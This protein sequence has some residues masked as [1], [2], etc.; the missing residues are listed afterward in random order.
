MT[1]IEHPETFHGLPVF[2]LPPPGEEGSTPASLPESGSVAWRLDCA[3]EGPAFP[4]IWQRFLD[5]VDPAAVRALLIGPWWPDGYTSFAPV[6]ELIVSDAARFPALRALFLADVVGEECEVS[7]L[8]MSDITSLVEAYPR[9]EELVVRG[10]G[11]AVPEEEKLQLRP[12]RHLALKS[13]R[14]ES[15]GLPG[16]VVRAVG[17]SELPALERLE[18]WFGASWYGGDATV[19]DMRPVLSGSGLPRLRHLGLQNSEIQD[20]IAA[21]VASAPVVAQLES[22]SLSMGTLSDTGATAL[23]NGQ[24][25]TH[26][27]SLDLHHHYLTEPVTSRVRELCAREGVHVEL[28][29]ADYWDP[30]DD[31]PRYV[32]VSE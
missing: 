5:T 16:H 10:G 12:V 8:E 32:A 21:A 29:E 13:L 9:L 30:E 28:D 25:L 2:T 6:A 3:W 1:D 24:P 26:L 27:T 19:E 31:E 11:D 22:L 14:F 23:L 20:E 15:G 4:G 18:F 17:A 7:W